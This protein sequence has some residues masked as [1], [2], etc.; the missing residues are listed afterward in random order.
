MS[1]V[2]VPLLEDTRVVGCYACLTINVS[3]DEPLRR[4]P[5][6]VAVRVNGYLYITT[7]TN[8]KLSFLIG[9]DRAKEFIKFVENQ[10]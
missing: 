1:P 3:I 8:K 9:K 6:L 7:P 10:Y 4:E 5:V 2:G